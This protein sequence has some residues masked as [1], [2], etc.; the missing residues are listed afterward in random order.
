MT[1]RV[2][3]EK[4]HG[5]RRRIARA[6]VGAACITALVGLVAANAAM[7]LLGDTVE[8]FLSSDVVSVTPGQSEA[9]MRA[10]LMLAERV[11]GEGLVLVRNEGDVLPLST[12][13]GQINVFGWSSTQWVAAGSGSGQVAG[14]TEGLL[15]ALSKRGVSYNTQLADMYRS[16]CGKRA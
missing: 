15:D 13:V 12:D 8:S 5:R 14:D 9:T 2:R 4:S 16:F 7:V 11:E 1:K 10:G 6:A 3:S